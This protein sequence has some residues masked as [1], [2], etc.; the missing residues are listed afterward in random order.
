MRIFAPP[1]TRR[2]VLDAASEACVVF[3]RHERWARSN[4]RSAPHRYSGGAKCSLKKARSSR[5]ARSAESW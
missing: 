3:P 5:Q 1:R 2:D 4:E